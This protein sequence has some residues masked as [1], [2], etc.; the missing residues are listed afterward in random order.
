MD[1]KRIIEKASMT[2]SDLASGGLLNPQQFNQF[3]RKMIDQPTILRD[4][5]NVPMNSDQMKIEKLGF[6]QRILHPGEETKAL[7]DGQR[8]K[9]ATGKIELNAREVIAEVNISY[10]TLENNIEG[11]SLQNTLV[12]MLAE[13]ASLDIEELLVNGDKSSSDPYLALLDGLRKQATSHVVDLAG[14]DFDRQA[15]KKLYAS[16]PAKYLR[17]PADFRYYMSHV[18]ELN[19]RDVVANRQTG[20]GDNTLI[21]AGVPTAYG[22]PVK[23]IAML[24]P[25][26]T[27]I[28]DDEE[29]T[30]VSDILLT[31]PKNMIVGVSRNVRMEFD[32]DIR[33]RTF[34]I[35]LTMKLD[36]KFEEEDAVAKGINIKHEVL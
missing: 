3:H 14:A 12:D 20:L 16:V 27:T 26:G 29:S 35:V 36:T 9:P 18:N 30:Q 4:A 31:N 15:L 32:K 28:G 24:Q 19:W 23:G 5:R 25:Y 13:R 10:D 33:S 1:N 34:I 7:T 17:N 22:V 8:S 6:G 11:D 21:G 2:L